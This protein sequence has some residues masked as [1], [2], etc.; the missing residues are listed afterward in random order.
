MG[1]G[2]VHPALA[3]K[4]RRRDGLATTAVVREGTP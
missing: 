3:F 1:S 2:E 4:D